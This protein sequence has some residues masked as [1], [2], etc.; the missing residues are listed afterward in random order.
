MIEQEAEINKSGT[1]HN[2]WEH[3]NAQ[4][5]LLKM[6]IKSINPWQK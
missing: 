5:G 3:N 6:L 4:L 1:A 2:N